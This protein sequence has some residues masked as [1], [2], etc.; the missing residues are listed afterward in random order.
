MVHS[1]IAILTVQGSSVFLQAFIK[2]RLVVGGQSRPD[3][4]KK[5]CQANRYQSVG[6]S[7]SQS[8]HS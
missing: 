1:L 7:V 3:T 2:H 8:R 4:A 5:K 6:D